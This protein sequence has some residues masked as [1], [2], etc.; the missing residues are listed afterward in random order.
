MNTTKRANG[1]KRRGQTAKA[2][3]AAG[4]AEVARAT[5]RLWRKHHLSYDQSK[6]VVERARRALGLEPPRTRRRTVERLDYP[7]VERL[8]RSAY[9]DRSAYGIMIKTLFLTG[10]RVEEFVHIRVEDLHLDDELPQICLRHAKRQACRYV[11]VL[12][13]LAQ[14]LRT[15]LHGRRLGYLF[16][17]NRHTR[18]SVRTVQAVVKRCAQRAGIAKRVYPHL[19]RHSIATILLDS[20]LVPIDQVQKFLGHLQLSTTQI[21]AETSARALGENYVRALATAHRS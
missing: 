18:Y 11:P 2:Q 20:G 21:Y 9:R 6:Y 13:D 4:L 14:E 1:P 8:I 17:S 16:E 7:E 12:P 10:A 19:L 5:G 3:S 15:H